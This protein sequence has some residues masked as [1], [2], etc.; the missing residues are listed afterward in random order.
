MSRGADPG[1][2][3]PAHVSLHSPA[4]SYSCARPCM[5]G[6]CCMCA[7]PCVRAHPCTLIRACWSPN[8]LPAPKGLKTAGIKPSLV[9]ASSLGIAN[10]TFATTLTPDDGPSHYLANSWALWFCCC[11][12]LAVK[13]AAVESRNNR[14][15]VHGVGEL[16]S[17]CWR[18]SS[19]TGTLEAAQCLSVAVMDV[20]GASAAQGV[21]HSWGLP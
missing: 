14:S 17:G 10:K 3:L 15:R 7:C 4:H 8:T 11:S 13:A 16:P 9:L 12:D 2:E 5:R 18:D 1:Q 20:D 19:A 21:F 6:C